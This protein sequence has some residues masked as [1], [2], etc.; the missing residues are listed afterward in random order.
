MAEIRAQLGQLRLALGLVVVPGADVLGERIVGAARPPLARHHGRRSASAGAAR[1]RTPPR[2]GTGR[3][4][5][6]LRERVLRGVARVLAVGEHVSCE[7]VD[8]RRMADAERL[9]GLAVSVSGASH[10]DRVAEPLVQERALGPEGR[11]DLTPLAPGRLHP[12]SLLSRRRRC[13]VARLRPAERPLCSPP[14]RGRR[15]RACAPCGSRSTAAGPPEVR[16]RRRSEPLT[17]TVT[18][19]ASETHRPAAAGRAA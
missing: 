14:R 5:A 7:A 9:E 17:R 8:A 6:Y 12:A 18:V 13:R 15:R 19:A 3:S 1:S 10:E 11:A 2:R 16:V 4:W